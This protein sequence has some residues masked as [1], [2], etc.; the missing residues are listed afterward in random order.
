MR[1]L[2]VAAAA[3]LL[4]TGSAFAQEQEKEV[5]QADRE[6]ATH[7]VFGIDSH[8]FVSIDFTRLSD[9][10]Q[11]STGATAGVEFDLDPLWIGVDYRFRDVLSEVEVIDWDG[12]FEAKLGLYQ[13]GVGRIGDLPCYASAAF[14]FSRPSGP[15]EWATNFELGAEFDINPLYI[16]ATYVLR[17]VFT[18]GGD[19]YDWNGD[20]TLSLGAYW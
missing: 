18:D 19:V 14:L 6:Q 1:T 8:P 10:G 17:D 13:G 2:L 11:W 3:A 7:E 15:D 9:V 12:E 4:L 5:K 16:G 20:F